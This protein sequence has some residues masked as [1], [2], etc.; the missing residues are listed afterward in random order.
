MRTSI[1]AIAALALLLTGCAGPVDPTVPEQTSAPGTL[2]DGV[3]TV[4]AVELV[5]VWKVSNAAREGDDTYLRLADDLMVWNDCG[6]AMGSWRAQKDAFIATID[7]WSGDS[8]AFGDEF[9]AA[10]VT[11]ATGYGYVH[12]ELSLLDSDGERLAT[13]TKDGKPRID[14]NTSDDHREQP[15]V[16]ELGYRPFD[17]AVPLPIEAVP[18]KSIVGRWL[19]A[20]F[21]GPTD[22]YLE[23]HSDGTYTG[24]D[25]CNGASGRWVAGESGAFLATSG[26]STLIGC[27]GSNEA[28]SVGQASLVGMVGD[29]LT[30]YDANGSKLA[31]LVRE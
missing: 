26:P 28:H 15:V 1:L 16:S 14:E 21:D 30:L 10:W 4:P 12:G 20:D 19:P 31:A 24:S 3:E 17:D 6:I 22:P 2:D 25:G 9:P 5:G 13:L 23:F 18:I 27:E 7:G 8:C 29:E 11:T